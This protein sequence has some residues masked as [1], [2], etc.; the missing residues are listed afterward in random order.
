MEWIECENC[1]GEGF[2]GHDC[3][4]DCC[5]C[6]DPEDNVPCDVCGG[7]GGYWEKEGA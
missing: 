7:K 5:C 6:L 1:G 2:V 4:E 3:G